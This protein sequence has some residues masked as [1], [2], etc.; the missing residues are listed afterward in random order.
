[1]G[2]KYKDALHEAQ[3]E[4]DRIEQRRSVLL[5]LI[6]N[7]KELSED[8]A[9]ELMPPDG[10]VPQGLTEEIRTILGLTT[11]HLTPPEI[12]DSLINRG[13]KAS[14]PKN[15]L[16]GVHTVISRLF[17][18]R[19]LDVADKD[20]KPAYRALSRHPVDHIARR[21]NSPNTQTAKERFISAQKAREARK[22]SR[23]E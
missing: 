9:Y 10:Y 13:F 16:I 15:L 20:G 18:A 19:E 17:D 6:Q 8:D 22:E 12:R 1:M 2:D 23:T 14:S 21:G 4:L 7:L 3:E 11:V 5:R